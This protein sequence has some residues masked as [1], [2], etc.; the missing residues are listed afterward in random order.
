VY[1][2]KYSGIQGRSSALSLGQVSIAL[3]TELNHAAA[4]T[5][6]GL[7]VFS[8]FFFHRLFFVRAIL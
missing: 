7:G 3:Y 8:F 2:A 6:G 1:A 4:L 5:K